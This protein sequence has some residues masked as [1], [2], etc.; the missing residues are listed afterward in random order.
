MIWVL[1][2]GVVF[3]LFGGSKLPQLAKALGQSKRAFKEGLDEA[4][5]EEQEKERKQVQEG[6]S[7]LAAI[8]DEALL[9]EVR[10][11]SRPQ[12]TEPKK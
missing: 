7:P 9:E 3:L 5:R 6:K 12:V 10:R 11:R 8:D 4:E 1:I 2:V